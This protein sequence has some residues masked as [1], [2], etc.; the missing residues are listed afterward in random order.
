M[1]VH[2]HDLL[3]KDHGFSEDFASG[4]KVNDLTKKLKEKEARARTYGQ[5][6]RESSPAKKVA[7]PVCLPKQR[8]VWDSTVWRLEQW[9]QVISAY[10]KITLI[11]MKFHN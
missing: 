1:V 7:C 8:G 3:T 10:S 6:L 9:L 4:K 2:L 5:A 11:S